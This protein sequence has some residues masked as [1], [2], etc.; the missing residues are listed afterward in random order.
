MYFT[1]NTTLLKTVLNTLI[2]IQWKDVTQTHGTPLTLS[3]EDDTLTLSVASFDM[4]ASY[5]IPIE[6]KEKKVGK[7]VVL[8]QNEE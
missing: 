6:N 7:E 8:F 1:T 3:F 4:N 5:T 2:K